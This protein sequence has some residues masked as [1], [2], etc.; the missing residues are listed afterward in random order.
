MAIQA[1]KECH[2][3]YYRDQVHYGDHSMQEIVMDKKIPAG[4]GCQ[5]IK[6]CA[7]L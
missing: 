7:L 5:A 3:F 6:E 4:V 1:T 2:F